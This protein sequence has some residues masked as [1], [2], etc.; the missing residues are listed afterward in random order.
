MGVIGHDGPAGFTRL[1]SGYY[2]IGLIDPY[3]ELKILT[4]QYIKSFYKVT[5]LLS[6]SD[7]SDTYDRYYAAAKHGGIR[8]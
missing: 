6:F 8:Q 5:T 4:Y 1:C 3:Q 2:S 7:S